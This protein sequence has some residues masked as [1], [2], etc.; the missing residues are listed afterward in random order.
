MR[1]RERYFGLVE[2]K[3]TRTHTAENCVENIVLLEKKNI[4][5]VHTKMYAYFFFSS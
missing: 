3:Y 2:K 1:E 4:E 5:W